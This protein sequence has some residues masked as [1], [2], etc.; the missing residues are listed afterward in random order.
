M[1][2]SYEGVKLKGLLRGYCALSARLLTALKQVSDGIQVNGLH[3]KVLQILHAGDCV[4]LCL[5]EDSKLPDPVPAPLA[6]V[7]EG[8]GPACG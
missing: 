3:A 2:P 1:P 5:P 6:V 4:R 8:C 7:Y